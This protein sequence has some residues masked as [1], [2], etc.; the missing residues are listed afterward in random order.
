MHYRF[1][2]CRTVAEK[3]QYEAI[4]ECLEDLRDVLD[5]ERLGF[6]D[7]DIVVS[8]IEELLGELAAE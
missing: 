8:R 5:D 6:S 7:I 4:R 1:H 3:A 2:P